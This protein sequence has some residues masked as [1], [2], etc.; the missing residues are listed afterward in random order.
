MRIK[1]VDCLIDFFSEEIPASMQIF[2]E[3]EFNHIFEKVLNNAL[4][5]YEKIE[6]L[7]SPRHHSILI[8]KIDSIQKDQSLDI[9]GPR[10]NAPKL[11]VEGFLK[12]NKTTLKKL[13]I[14]KTNKGEFYFHK[15]F[16]KGKK[17][18]QLITDMI[19]E[20]CTSISWPKSQRWGFSD[21]KW[22]RP[23]RNIM[24][25]IDKSFV[26]GKIKI[27]EN[28][29]I[30]FKNYTYGHRSLNKTVKVNSPT[31]FVNTMKSSYV[32]VNRLD[33]KK[34]IEI[35]ISKI[36]KKLNLNYYIDDDLLNEVT[37]LVEFPNVLVGK[38][39]KQYMKLPFEILSI[40]MK[41]HQK[42]FSLAD[43]SKKIAPYFLVVSNLK[44]N[45]QTDKNVVKG[46]ERVLKA[47]LSDALFFWEYDCKN[48]L[49]FYINKLKTMIFHEGLGDL[50]KRSL[51]LSKINENI[52][53]LFNINDN[54]KLNKLGL[55]SKLDLSSNLVGEFP[56]LQGTMLKYLAKLNGFSK[57]MQLAFEDQYK[58]VGSKRIMPRNKLGSILSIS[59]N[60]D[61]L[62]SFFSIGLIPT[63][64]RDPFAL[65]RSGNSLI[66]V[67]WSESNA[68][69]LNKLIKALDEKFN[70]DIKL[71]NEIK[72]FLIDRLYNFLMEQGFRSDKLSAI[73]LQ[74]NIDQ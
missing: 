23:L 33:R 61:I 21:L 14:N 54:K 73:I 60:I 67:L 1:K 5:N 28:D 42:Y 7:S 58:P 62:S 22:G 72:N 74:D 56:E 34:A 38:I 64:S 25:L 46:N 31:G 40:V 36:S 6:I 57:D 20:V 41:V 39:D 9:K 15:K 51:R 2:L 69:S 26:N 71:V 70:K 16:I 65:R 3:K 44:P 48:A 52:G 35:Q 8:H 30:K 47:R 24:V 45:N 43:N 17:F 13:T 32:F 49:S 11:A 18:S 68:L 50:Y 10:I 55:Y 12:T 59:N 27:N 53:P 4:L 66:S 29:F 63:G 37:G 19:Q